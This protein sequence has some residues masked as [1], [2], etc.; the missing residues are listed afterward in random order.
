[1]SRLTFPALIALLGLLVVATAVSSASRARAERERQQAAEREE[2]REAPAMT[3]ASG[4]V[5][6][7]AEPTQAEDVPP[8]PAPRPRPSFRLTKVRGGGSVALRGRPGGKVV[9]RLA[10]Q[11]EFGSRRV[12]SVAETR[13]RWLGVTSEARPNGRLG[14]VDSRS[15]A[16]RMSRTR[17][18]LHADLS[19]RRLEL[20]RGRRVIKRITVTI[21]RPGSSTPTG[22]FAV[23]DKISGTRY[24]SYYGCCILALSGRQPNLPA[25]WT[26]GDRLAIHGTNAPGAIGKAASAGC[27]RAADAPLRTLMRRVPVGTPVFIR[28]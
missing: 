14:W 16:L 27:L 9:T 3:A 11:T 7:P 8:R 28:G 5:R 17:M 23:T 25:G 21:G 6:Q 26:G 10:S 1:M 22:R 19:E 4:D 20:R 15:D 13:G 18:S 2:A 12:L 24:G